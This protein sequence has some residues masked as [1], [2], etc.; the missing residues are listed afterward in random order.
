MPAPNRSAKTTGYLPT[1]DGW[2]ALAILAVMLSH[3]TVHRLGP[4]ST[5]WFYEHG[6]L[7]VDIFFAISGILI[8]SRLLTEE[9]S[10]GRISRRSFYIRRTFRILPPAMLF[11]ATLL[12]LKATVE[13][14]VALPEVLSSL[15]FVRNYTA[16]FSHFQTLYPFYTSHFWS[17]AV[18]E[19][20]YL[21]LPSLLVFTPKKYRV[22]ALLALAA[23]V[24]LHRIVPNSWLSFHTDIR[25]DALL[26]PAALAVL[27][28]TPRYRIKL[29]RIARFAPIVA[30]ILFL[31]V[32]TGHLP[33]TTGLLIAWLTPLLILGTLLHP[34]SWLSRLLELQ[35]LRYLGRISYSLYLWQQLFLISHFGAGTARLGMLQSWP[36]NWMMAFAC[37][38][39]SYYLVEQPMIRLGHR[40][41]PNVAANRISDLHEPE[42][43]L[44][45]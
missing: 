4:L 45:G 41:E 42:S 27:L 43:I 28:A 13:L 22:A 11:L 36:L 39:L 29:A 23:A 3:D 16:T 9:K 18:E 17:L 14:P 1:L 5:A 32:T 20:F 8:C 38:I 35:P 19:H 40:L 30:A 44:A 7:G 26:V 34:A 37:A 6:H 12:V 2:R 33:R 25:L 21:I 24:S 15:F 31:M 10:A